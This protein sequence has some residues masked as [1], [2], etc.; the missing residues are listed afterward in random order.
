MERRH[1]LRAALAGSATMLAAR[2]WWPVDAVAGPGVCVL[3]E[4]A[5]HP[6]GDLAG[7][8]FG[9]LPVHPAEDFR[10][11]A[12]LLADG[13]EI[14]VALSFPRGSTQRAAIVVPGGRSPLCAVVTPTPGVVA[15]RT[16]L[17]LDRGTGPTSI[18]A[19]AAS[20]EALRQ[21]SATVRLTA[22]GYGAGPPAPGTAPGRERATRTSIKARTVGPVTKV[23]AL[24]DGPVPPAPL[25]SECRQL[26]F[27][28]GGTPVAR[29]ELGPCAAASG[30][31]GITL[32][33]R[34]IGTEVSVGWTDS[35]GSRG[36]AVAVV[37]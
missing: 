34:L 33:A 10:L 2:P 37:A 18:L 4:L 35:R 16:R 19:F 36:A 28:L 25:P 11:D 23:I 7:A 1:L 26:V 29:A 14:A 6:P 15:F 12:P 32:D 22:G 31:A 13:H 24:V 27:A 5:S 8:L 17:R 30:F 9:K 20:G 21:T 3:T